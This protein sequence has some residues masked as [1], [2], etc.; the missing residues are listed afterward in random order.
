[1][2][3]DS[4][5]VFL[6]DSAMRPP[7]S[8]LIMEANAVEAKNAKFYFSCVHVCIPRSVAELQHLLLGEIGK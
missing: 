7:E 4:S 8:A 1:M 3:D 5:I 6:Q 2:T